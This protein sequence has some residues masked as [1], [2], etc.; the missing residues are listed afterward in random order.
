MRRRELGKAGEGLLKRTLFSQWNRE[1]RNQLR[2]RTETD[3]LG[4]GGGEDEA[5]NSHPGE[6]TREMQL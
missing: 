4:V 2:L 5:W 3:A 1:Q 6:S